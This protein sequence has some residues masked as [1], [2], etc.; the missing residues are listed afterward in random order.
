MIDMV[1]QKLKTHKDGVEKIFENI[2]NLVR[3]AKS[4]ILESNWQRLGVLMNYNQD[5]LEDLGV[6]TQKINDLVVSARQAGAWGAKLSGAGAGDCI[7]AL[8]SSETKMRVAQAIEKSG[9]KIIDVSSCVEGV[10]II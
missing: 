7:I 2:D 1:K 5:Y 3:Q 4:A 6:S 8:V 10:K 9:G